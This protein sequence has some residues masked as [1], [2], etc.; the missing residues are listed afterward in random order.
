L[1]LCDTYPSWPSLIFIC[2]FL[3][4]ALF[5]IFSERESSSLKAELYNRLKTQGQLLRDYVTHKL[6][7]GG[8]LSVTKDGISKYI[9][10][11]NDPGMDVVKGWNPHY[12]LPGWSHRTSIGCSVNFTAMLGVMAVNQLAISSTVG[13]YTGLLICQSEFEEM[14]K[15][16]RVNTGVY[17]T[18]SFSSSLGNMLQKWNCSIDNCLSQQ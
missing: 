12:S 11:W 17:C 10:R 9:Y 5:V 7:G 18:E 8:F 13:S 1:L 2:T 15:H 6:P 3:F 4:H 14:K 16:L